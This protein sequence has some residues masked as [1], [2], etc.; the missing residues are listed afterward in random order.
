MTSHIWLIGG[1]QES[2]QLALS[3]TQDQIPFVVTATTESA[4]SLY[5]YTPPAQIWIGRLT[6]E[7][8][9]GFLKSQQIGAILD[10]SH[11]YAVSISQLAMRTATQNHIP[12][13][14]YERLSCSKINNGKESENVD[15]TS[16]LGLEKRFESFSDLLATDL[17]KNQR[18]LLTVGYQALQQFQAWQQQA[19]LFARI[20]PSVVALEAA[21]AAGFTPDRLIA[22]RPPLSM[23]FERALWQHWQPTVVVSKASGEPGGESIKRALAAELGITLALINRPVLPYPQQT[24]ELAVALEFCQHFHQL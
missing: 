15:N 1:T 12:Y 3:L 11:P 21:I 8:L 5:P 6:T 10:A 18:V 4:R 2:A 13:L 23:A 19:T 9:P 14:R 17:L 20:L 16:S 7:Q 24:S 22:I